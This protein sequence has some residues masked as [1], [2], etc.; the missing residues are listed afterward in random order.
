[1]KVVST[2]QMRA[3]EAAADAN[4]ISFRTMFERVAQAAVQRITERLAAIEEPRV[5]ILVGGGNNGGDGL[6]TALKLAEDERFTVAVYLVKPR[7]D[8]DEDL[9]AL[10]K[11]NAFIAEA[12]NDQ[13]YRVL[14]NTVASANLVVDAVFGIGVRLPLEGDIA[15]ILRNVQQAI[16]TPP[17]PPTE[18]IVYTPPAAQHPAQPV[19]PFVLAL[20]CPSGIDCDSGEADKHAISADETLTFIAV[21]QGL[22]LN[23]AAAHVGVLSLAT[24]GIPDDLPELKSQPIDFATPSH[25][26]AMLPPQDDTGHKYSNGKVMIAAGSVN[27]AG[28]AGLA[29]L[30]AYRAGAGLVT[31]A[32]PMPVVAGLAAQ[33]LEPTWVMLPHDMGVIGEKA[34]E[35]LLKEIDGYKALLIGPGLGTEETTRDMLVSLLEQTA[36]E[37]PKRRENRPI[38][39]L[40]ANK[41]AEETEAEAEDAPISLPPL[42]LDADALNL[43]AQVEDWPQKLPANT[44]ITPHTGE[45]ARLCKLETAEVQANRL[46]LAREKAEAWHVNV[47]LKGAHTVIAAPDG[48]TMVLPFKTAAL[49][50][51]G[52]GDVLAGMIVSL[53]GQGLAPFDAAVVGAYLHGM[54]G[55]LAGHQRGAARSV[56]ASDVAGQI[57]TA[58]GHLA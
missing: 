28:A 13:Q 45:M 15:K 53:L 21:K 47:L 55:V 31:V 27:Y 41:P 30:G 5:T 29:A 43:L 58:L 40:R 2:E 1:M 34:A 33:V 12:E 57:G 46:T 18:G 51:A 54:A 25:I 56:V 44:I 42:V 19:R 37:A 3:I 49:A 6:V 14:R 24:L 7:P 22:L 36:A 52:T 32:A 9:A 50:T 26:R 17:P 8:D 39:F 10:R 16:N 4:G 48:R 20:D 35:V 38:G 23:P 11:T